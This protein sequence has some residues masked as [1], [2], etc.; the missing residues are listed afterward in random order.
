MKTNNENI[1]S[2]LFVKYFLSKLLFGTKYYLSFFSV[3]VTRFAERSYI[4]FW[5]A[6]RRKEKEIERERREEM[7][8]QVKL[9]IFS[10]EA[11]G[12]SF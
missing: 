10:G 1:N 9:I 7:S 11:D 5:F 12:L 6:R 8:A 2:L 3:T 4:M